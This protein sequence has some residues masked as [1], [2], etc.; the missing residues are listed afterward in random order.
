M[1]DS[2]PL[3]FMSQVSQG[4]YTVESYEARIWEGCKSYDAFSLNRC[5]GFSV[6]CSPQFLHLTQRSMGADGV[7][8]QTSSTGMKQNF[9]HQRS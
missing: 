2:S 9:Q 7:Q 1:L 4:M 6:F 5:V 3:D 8:L